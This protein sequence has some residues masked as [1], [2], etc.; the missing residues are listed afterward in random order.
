MDASELQVFHSRMPAFDRYRTPCSPTVGRLAEAIRTT[1]GAVR[2]NHPQTSFAAVGPQASWLC[3]SHP[4]ESHLDDFSPLGRLYAVHASVLLVGVPSSLLTPYHLADCRV[5]DPPRREYACV[6]SADTGEPRWV[7]FNGVDLTDVH[8][9]EM[10]AAVRRK[11]AFREG[12][13]GSADAYLVPIV[14]A[15]DAATVWWARDRT[16]T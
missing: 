1:A 4:L 13:L 5:P 7:T 14:P 12:A 6:L 2:S 16:S 11:V 15:V 10:G 3:D 9:P 8:F